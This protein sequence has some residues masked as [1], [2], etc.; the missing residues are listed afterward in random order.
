MD[1]GGGSTEFI[2]ADNKGVK[3]KQS[4]DIGASRLLEQFKPSDP[5]LPKEIN[6]LEKFLEMTLKPLE[7]AM[8]KF[9]A[10]KLA[11]SSGSFETLAEIIGYRFHNKNVLKGKISYWFNLKEY[12]RIH[13][14]LLAST[15]AM[16][17][18]TKGLVK[19]R[20]DMIV[21]SSILTDFI[22]KKYHPSEMELSKYA[23]KEG[24]LV[25]II[26]GLK[27]RV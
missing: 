4:F 1:I 20:V 7:Q 15:T 18:K 22:L 13:Q 5:I 3:W 14:W 11:G 27:F 21:I 17:M 23:L 16:R 10:K 6:A 19:M 25:K 9:P 8:K 24:A 12:H 26:S 2:I